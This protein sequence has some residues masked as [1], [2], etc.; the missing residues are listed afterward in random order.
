MKRNT[1]LRVK[2]KSLAEEAKII[3]HE[4]KKANGFK[5]YR[6]QNELAEHRKG[7]VRR[8]TRATILAYQYLRGLA[9]S[10]CESPNGN[11]GNPISWSSVKRMISKYGNPQQRKDFDRSE[12][13]KVLNFK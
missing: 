6:L 3:Q 8:E 4:E 11:E 7:I 13:I 1:F 10:S 9:Y 2:L 12:W 5:N